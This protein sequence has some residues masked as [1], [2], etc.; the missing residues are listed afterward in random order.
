MSPL[1]RTIL[2]GVCSN[3]VLSASRLALPLVALGLGASEFVVG[4]LAALVMVVP[5]LTTVSFGR[6]MDRVGALTPMKFAMTL[7]VLSG[8]VPVVSPGLPALALTALLTGAAAAYTHVAT[9]KAVGSAGTSDTRVRTLGMLGVAYSAT[10][11]VAPLLVGLAYDHAGA[12][13]AFLMM[14]LLPMAAFAVLSTG[15]HLYSTDATTSGAVVGEAAAGPRP[16]LLRDGRLRTWGLIYAVF[17]GALSLFPIVVALH[18]TQLGM[19]AAAISGFLAAQAIGMLASRAAV[20]L[21]R[22]PF[23]RAILVGLALLVA[24]GAY[25][26]VPFLSAWT[27]L[28]VVSVLLG[29]ATGLG[30]PVSM[31]MVYETA[32]PDRINEAIALAA[33]AA[34]LIQLVTPFVSGSLARLYG[35]GV[36]TTT[37]AA[38]LLVA[39]LVGSFRARA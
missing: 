7:A 27:A 25:A 28:A 4:V 26:A 19:S 31:S 18:G 5:V 29:A 38:I 20:S 33:I 39:A 36:M 11:F 17:Q 24:A 14:A 15:P 6:W 32:P 21:F 37:I 8:L 16:T 1:L 10:M 9:I 30:Q 23:S 12:R 13:A 3:S 22:I 35:I 2:V 34:N